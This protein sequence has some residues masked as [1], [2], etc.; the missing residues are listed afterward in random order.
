[1]ETTRHS[2]RGE[3]AQ[4]SVASQPVG[5]GQI[6]L[7][8][9]EVVRSLQRTAGNRAVTR[10]LQRSPLS[11]RLRGLWDPADKDPWFDALRALSAAE[12]RDADVPPMIDGLLTGND[13]WLSHQIVL[14]G[15]ESAWATTPGARAEIAQSERGAPIEAFFYPGLTNERALVIA[16]VHGTEAQGRDVARMLMD[17]LQSA[18]RAPHFTVIVVPNLFPDS[19]AANRR[20]TVHRRR[21]IPSNRNFPTEAGEQAGTT[22]DALGNPIV[23]ENLALIGLMKHFGPSRVISIHGTQRPRLAGIFV[24]PVAGRE[25]A[26]RNRA[27]RAAEATA[28]GVTDPATRAA[29]A[30]RGRGG[31]TG[32]ISKR[33]RRGELPGRTDARLSAA[34][35]ARVDDSAVVM[36]NQLFLGAGNENPGWG[37]EVVPGVSLGQ[38]GPPRGMTV[39]TVEPAVN[40]ALEDYPE[41]ARGQA[42]TRDQRRVELQAYADAIRTVLLGPDPSPAAGAGAGAAAGSAS[43]AAAGPGAAA[44]EGAAAGAGAQG[45]PVPAR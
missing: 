40:R 33:M 45:Q 12:R 19:A 28:A 30:S 43:G 35:Q 1:V 17:D 21:R 36:G 25:Q 9:P 10:L 42:M 14:F 29:I 38:Y 8:G 4:E 11:D 6:P 32:D 31:L 18:P 26:D 37:G 7:T 27:I 5:L 24:D 15:P 44:G 13:L 22:T 3:A 16:G 41:S 39:Y 2:E 34:E 23:A 20:E